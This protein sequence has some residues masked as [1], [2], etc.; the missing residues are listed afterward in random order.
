MKSQTLHASRCSKECYRE[1]GGRRINKSGRNIRRERKEVIR[2]NR[3]FKEI[4]K[5]VFIVS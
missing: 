2:K 1:R 4:Q 5:Q 3:D